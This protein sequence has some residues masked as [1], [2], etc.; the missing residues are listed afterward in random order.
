M[1]PFE[2]E[3]KFF[4]NDLS[5]LRAAAIDLGATVGL[6][7]FEKNVRFEDNRSS[8][9]KKSA[10]LRLRRDDKTRLTFK[11]PP[12]EQDTQFKVFRELEVKVSDFDTMAAILEALGYL[13][14]QIYEKRRETLALP[15]AHLCLDEL[16]FGHFLEIEGEKSAIRETAEK[17]GLPWEKRILANYLELFEAVRSAR[18]LGFNDVTFD[19][20]SVVTGNFTEVIRAFETGPDS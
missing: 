5:A 6:K 10:L 7:S 8:L 12:P 2:V 20:F 19:A 1:H 9:R 17:L 18:N 4:I 3:V 13:P 14:A 15:G 16:P 11:S